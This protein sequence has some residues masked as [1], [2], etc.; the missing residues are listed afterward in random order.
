M[1]IVKKILIVIAVLLLLISAIG[2]IFFPSQ[3]HVERSVVINKDIS[4]VYDQISN[5]KNFQSWSPWY[6]RDT[7]A[8]YTYS[9]PESGAGQSLHWDSKEKT[10]GKGSLTIADL[11]EDSVVN[12]DLAM[13]GGGGVAKAIYTLSPEGDAT[14][15]TWSMNMD[16]GMNP[17]MRI[18][19]KFMDGMVGPDFEQGLNK[20]K[21]RV[22]SM[23]SSTSGI[24]VEEVEVPETDYLFYHGKADIN[25]ISQFLGSSYQKIGVAMR[26]QKLQMAGAP[27]AIY[28]TDSQTAWEIDAAIA[29]NAP[30][31]DDGD[32]K[33]GKLKA[34]K[35]VM[36][37]FFGSYDQ[38]PMGHKAADEYIKK[39][40]KQVS[41][42]PWEV[43]VTD[44]GAEKDTAKW[45]KDIYYPV[46]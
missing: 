35:A 11:V 29:V 38:T 41:G 27:F 36:V 17:L 46:Q 24:S 6:E 26:K 12:M 13:D 31:K 25:N 1:K 34:G 42:A 32:I 2:L 15:M 10:V 20:L 14:K 18:M 19:G 8:S 3:I 30:G 9:G 45:E 39:N 22:E 21:A 37:R 43:Y 28:Y 23:P 44:P 7:A 4:T 5:L 33:A 40:N 16:A